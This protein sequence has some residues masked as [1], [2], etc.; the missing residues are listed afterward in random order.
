MPIVD[1]RVRFVESNLRF[2]T[3][4]P[5]VLESCWE[6]TEDEQK[7]NEEKK[8]KR[9]GSTKRKYVEAIVYDLF[10][11][12]LCVNMGTFQ[13]NAYVDATGRTEELVYL[14]DLCTCVHIRE[15]DMKE[16]KNEPSCHVTMSRL[17]RSG[18][19]S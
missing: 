10:M 6:S 8:K 2:L 18:K 17:S 1:C 4:D 7:K 16:S 19:P 11:T 9:R 5:I 3:N 12:D 13:V 14:S 15:S